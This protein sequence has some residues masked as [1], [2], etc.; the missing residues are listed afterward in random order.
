MIG[1]MIRIYKKQNNIIIN[2]EKE[3]LMNRFD[4]GSWFSEQYDDG[5]RKSYKVIQRFSLSD[6]NCVVE[7]LEPLEDN[8][9]QLPCWQ[10]VSPIPVQP[11][12]GESVWIQNQCWL[13]VQLE[14]G[15]QELVQGLV[16]QEV[17][18]ELVP[19]Y[20]EIREIIKNY[21][22]TS[23]NS[24]FLLQHHKQDPKQQVK[25]PLQKQQHQK[26]S[27]QNPPSS[28]REKKQE[29]DSN[30][31][32]QTLLQA[33]FSAV[34]KGVQAGLLCPPISLPDEQSPRKLPSHPRG[35]KKPPSQARSKLSNQCLIDLSV[36]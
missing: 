26:S 18:Q 1:I 12:Q 10:D 25:S 6:S 13:V 32:P 30:L 4:G 11:Y 33:P 28:H 36:S 19:L 35:L 20:N 7:L 29:Q 8:F 14:Q 27:S 22:K 34:P 31:P 15:Q 23:S 16:P 17:E 5:K 21:M 3:K 24:T 9:I 2:E